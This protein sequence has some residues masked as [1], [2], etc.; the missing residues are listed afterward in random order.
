MATVHGQFS[1]NLPAA[2]FQL[3]F[4][5][6]EKALVAGAELQFSDATDEGT[7]A[8]GAHPLAKDFSSS[9]N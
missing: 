4:P 1:S 6:A 8:S 7:V 2:I 5:T 3:Q 9:F